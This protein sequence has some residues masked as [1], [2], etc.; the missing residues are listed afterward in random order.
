MKPLV[1]CVEDQ[2][3][4]RFFLDYYL[5]DQF[6]V[7]GKADGLEAL[8]WLEE[9]HMPELIL[10]D[11]DMPGL[12]GARLLN[13]VR[14]SEATRNIPFVILSGIEDSQTRVEVLESGADDFLL[15]PFH[16]RELQMRIDIALKRRNN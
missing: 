1:L 12:D 14:S 9:G 8:A 3:M 13:I 10:A 2:Q 4:M 16:P 5:H 11:I 7:I 6:E 15:K